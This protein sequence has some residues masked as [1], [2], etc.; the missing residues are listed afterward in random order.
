MEDTPDGTVAVHSNFKPA[1]GSPCSLAQS[2]ALEIMNRTAREYGL[3]PS[4]RLKPL[5]DV[6]RSEVNPCG[7][8]L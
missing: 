5:P 1:I 3:P 6:I 7:S 2:A 4:S 8:D